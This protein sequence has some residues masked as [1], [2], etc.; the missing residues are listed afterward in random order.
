MDI[1]SVIVR[2]IFLCHFFYKMPVI[3][4]KNSMNQFYRIIDY[5]DGLYCIINYHNVFNQF[6]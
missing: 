1:K 5:N 2:S 4:R 3:F 6:I